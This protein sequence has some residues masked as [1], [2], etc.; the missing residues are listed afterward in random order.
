MGGAR[1]SVRAFGDRFFAALQY[2]EFRTLWSANASAQAAAWALIVIRGWLIFEK[3][4]SS[5]WVGFATFA[6]MGPQF[7]VPPVIGVLADRID[8]RTILVWTYTI[9]FV[10]AIALFAFAAGGM[11]SVGLLVVFSL[12]NGTARAAQMPTSQAMA[13]SLVPGESLLQALSLNASTQHGSRLIGPGLVTPVL[14][15]VGAPAAFALCIVLYGAGLFQIRTLTPRKPVNVSS[16]SFAANFMSGLSYVYVRPV[17]RFMIMLA[18]FHCALTMAFESLLP[19]F[20]H[21]SLHMDTSGF[22]TLMLGV[23]AGSFVTSILVSGVRTSR[24]RG[25]TLIVVG[26]LSG[27]GQV[28]LSMTGTIW[29]ALAA[30]ALMGGAQAAFM[31]IAQAL[32]QSIAADEYRG[33]VASINSFSLGG[34]MAVLNLLNGSLDTYFGASRLLFWE[35]MI[36]ILVV[37]LSLLAVSGRRVYG[38][39]PAIEASAA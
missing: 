24:A 23:G 38:R 9:N 8:R 37:L 16:G 21:E 3:T 2:P 5:F 10:Q 20:V 28:L 15:I 22:G 6:A 27:V 18:I 39:E 31:T 34:M 4:D 30:A 35:G 32:T 36:F 1:T 11:L 17:L 33:R 29:M 26:L 7:L 12:I 25:N 19:A 14:S 13:A